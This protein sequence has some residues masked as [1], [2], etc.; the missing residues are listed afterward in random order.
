MFLQEIR[1]YQ[2]E[3]YTKPLYYYRLLHE[4]PVQLAKKAAE[5]GDYRLLS[6]AMGD[7]ASSQDASVFGVKCSVPVRTKPLVFG[8]VPP[9]TVVFKLMQRFNIALIQQPGFPYKE[10]CKEDE[11]VTATMRKMEKDETEGMKQAHE[12]HLKE[13]AVQ[14]KSKPFNE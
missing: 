3:K 12:K 10:A 1:R 5:R 7:K 2:S 9:P 13:W 4:N 6:L 11:S 14:E 8:C